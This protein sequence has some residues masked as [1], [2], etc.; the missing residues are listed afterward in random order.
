MNFTH[1]ANALHGSKAWVTSDIKPTITEGRDGVFMIS[2]STE[3]ALPAKTL[4][5]EA[6]NWF[7]NWS[8][9][10]KDWGVQDGAN[11][12][13]TKQKQTNGYVVGAEFSITTAIF[14]RLGKRMDLTVTYIVI[15]SDQANYSVSFKQMKSNNFGA[16]GTPDIPTPSMDYVDSV[17][18]VQFK[19]DS[20]F[21][22]VNVKYD[23]KRCFQE[24]GSCNIRCWNQLPCPLRLLLLP[25]GCKVALFSHWWLD[26]AS[27]G[28]EEV[29]A[30]L[31]QEWTLQFQRLLS[32][33]EQASFNGA[34]EKKALV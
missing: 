32:A 24:Q 15:D 12:I 11:F 20:C 31:H 4:C 1:V 27:F 16:Y 33:V 7:S 14:D 13:E 22:S 8:E 29:A 30:G 34:M 28:E 21:M 19:N 9:T 25:L 5:K 3:A 6:F 26:P 23:R 17:W 2:L 10:A 18:T